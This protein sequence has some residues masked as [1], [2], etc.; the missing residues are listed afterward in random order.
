MTVAAPASAPANAIPAIMER[1]KASTADLHRHAESRPLQRSLAKGTIERAAFTT[2]LAQLLKVHESLEAKLTELLATR[3]DL[4]AAFQDDQR[5]TPN[6]VAD[7][8]H[9]GVDLEAVELHAAT[10]ELVRLIQNAG[11]VSPTALL[12]ML[13]VLEGS[14]NGSKYIARAMSR[15]VGIAPGA[16]G[17]SY[18]DP[19]G[20]RQMERWQ[21]FKSDMNAIGFEPAEA[22]AIVEGA[23]IMFNGIANVS[24]DVAAAS[25]A[26]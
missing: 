15:A 23:N 13:Y 22:D 21:Q 6:L 7:L 20:E 2:Y 19:Y 14:N 3:P 24:D 9:L 26:S 4:S 16:P 11:R 5:R 10:L 8:A 17:L 18:L 1:L 25:N 12:G